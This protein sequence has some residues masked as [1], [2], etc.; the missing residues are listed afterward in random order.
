MLLK[1]LLRLLLGAAVAARLVALEPREHRG[2]HIELDRDL[3]VRQR[4]RRSCRSRASPPRCRSDRSARAAHRPDRARSPNA[5]ARGRSGTW[6]P[7]G[8][9]PASF[10]RLKTAKDCLAIVRVEEI[11]E[12]HVLR[13]A[14]GLERVALAAG[15][16]RVHAEEFAG[17]FAAPGSS[18]NTG[19]SQVIQSPR[20]PVS[21]SGMRLIRVPSAALTVSNTCSAFAIGTL[22]TR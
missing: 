14:A 2:G 13:P 7:G 18:A 8:I 4:R 11:V 5:P 16:G 17:L 20:S 6:S 1:R 3:V 22:P 9:L 12:A 19:S 15:A 21:P 10:S